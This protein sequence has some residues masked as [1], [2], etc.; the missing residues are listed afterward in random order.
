MNEGSDRLHNHANALVSGVYY[1]DLGPTANPTTFRKNRQHL[2]S[3]PEHVRPQHK[4][5]LSSIHSG[6]MDNTTS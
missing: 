3:F 2:N 6:C 5:K 4:R 1:P